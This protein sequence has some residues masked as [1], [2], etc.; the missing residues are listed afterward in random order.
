MKDFI[1]HAVMT[2]SNFGGLELQ[3]NDQGIAVRIRE[4][5]GQPNQS[6]SEWIEIDFDVDCDIWFE[7]NDDIYY[8]HQFM[9]IENVS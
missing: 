3:L 5:H 4:N 7:Y 9:K 8:L 6:I 1:I 2:T